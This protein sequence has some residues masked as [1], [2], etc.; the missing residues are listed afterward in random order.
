[1]NVWGQ[2]MA[3]TESH[4]DAETRKASCPLFSAMSRKR[5]IG[6]RE[7]LAKTTTAALGA[8]LVVRA[9]ALGAGGYTA[10]SRRITM[11]A[12]G[13][14]GRG[15]N[16]FRALSRAGDVQA[17]AACD[18]Q[19]RRLE[20]FKSRGLDV[21]KDFRELLARGDIDAVVVASPSHWKPLH[22]IAAAKAG[23]DVFC[24]KPMSLTIGDGRAMVTAVRRYGRVFQHGTQQR[25][26][27]EFRFACEMV[28]SGRI[29]RLKSVTVNVGGPARDCY[30]PPEPVPRGVDWNM[31]LGPA[32][33]RPFNSAI[34]M[35]G[36]GGWEGFADYSGGG[37]TGWG[38]HHFDI[39]QWGLG[40]D[41]TGPVEIIP[42]DGKDVELLTY[43]YANG[44]NVHHSGHMGV[45]AV[46]FHGTEGRIAVNRGRLQTWPASI[47]R[48]PIR[49]HEVHLY[50]SPGHGANFLHCIRSRRKPIC[51]VET[52]HRTM[53]VCHLG[54][55]AYLL[56]RPLKWEPVKEAFIADPEADRFLD[57]ARREPWTL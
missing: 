11:A 31:W 25:S 43:K 22:T 44:V 41:E 38:S 2:R 47:M 17:V 6:R 1:M 19:Q 33:W 21:Y 57:R 35:R 18:V 27:R 40:T 24:E 46:V 55:I 20:P 26:S 53:S 29:G 15:T 14:G 13:V 34:C 49:P 8:P 4:S 9:S 5:R 32:P 10:P 56:R 39:A 54:N 16:V 36:C 50:T 12:I 45:W 3:T 51:D 23:A 48:E 52:G 30:L 42:P 28:R 37:M 7:F